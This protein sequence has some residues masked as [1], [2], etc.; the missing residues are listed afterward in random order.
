MSAP[1]SVACGATC[2][3]L[4]GYVLLLHQPGVCRYNLNPAARLSVLPGF[5][6]FTMPCPECCSDC[7]MVVLVH[8]YA[9]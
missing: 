8:V 6:S 4:D 9:V 3:H 7:M 2:L 5:D 1:H